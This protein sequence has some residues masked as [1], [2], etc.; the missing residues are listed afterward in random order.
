MQ[1]NWI[2]FNWQIQSATTVDGNVALSLL[3]QA[4]AL[5]TG[6]KFQWAVD[7]SLASFLCWMVD[8]EDT[9]GNTEK[10]IVRQ[11]GR[12]WQNENNDLTRGGSL[13]TGLAQTKE[14]L[15]N[16]WKQWGV[17]R[18][19]WEWRLEVGQKGRLRERQRLKGLEHMR[20]S[21]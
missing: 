11:T 9:L 21:G 17:R 15:R 10:S 5:E 4:R 13:A 8:F 18:I 20:R 3:K 16:E 12:Q 2:H 7:G 6:V 19:K 14:N 1:K